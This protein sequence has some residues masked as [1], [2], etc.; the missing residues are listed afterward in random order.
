MEGMQKDQEKM[1][2]RAT[3]I[4]WHMRGGIGREDVWRLSVQEFKSI[5]KF[6]E[7][8]VKIVEKTKL[9]LL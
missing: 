3:M 7:K 1:I 5:S 6:I 9:P 2:D 4:L 8:Q